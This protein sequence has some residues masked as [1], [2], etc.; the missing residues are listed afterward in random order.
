LPSYVVSNRRLVEAADLR[1]GCTVVD[2][3]CGGG[4]TL[5]A[6]FA[7]QGEI[8][9]AWAVDWVEAMVA[10][11]RRRLAGLP[12][13]FVVAPAESFARHLE[14]RRVDRVLSNGAFFQFRDPRKVLSEVASVLLPGGRLGFTLPGPSNTLEFL[15]LFHRLGL[16]QPLSGG[17]P[18]GQ[19]SERLT[20]QNVGSFLDKEG[21]RLVAQ[22]AVAVPTSQE[23]YIRWLSLPVFRRPEWMDWD[24]EELED[25]LR[26]ALAQTDLEPKV[27]WL[28]V[29][30]EPG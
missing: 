30:A 26:Q 23:A 14:G 3:A 1:P 10:E 24:R 11:A 8:A 19:A 4:A 18:G 28:L 2:L 20:F 7:R 13:S 27:S 9:A 21:W 5:E 17:P 16:T 12:V 15:A 6:A 25:K 29:I 22:E